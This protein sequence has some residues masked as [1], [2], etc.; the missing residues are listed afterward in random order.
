[1]YPYAIIHIGLSLVPA[2]LKV[3]IVFLLSKNINLQ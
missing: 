1:M 3:R 2:Y